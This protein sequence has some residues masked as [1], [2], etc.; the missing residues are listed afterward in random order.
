M[1]SCRVFDLFVREKRESPPGKPMASGKFDAIHNPKN[2]QRRAFTGPHR[3]A[4]D[5][6]LIGGDRTQLDC[7][8]GWFELFAG[9]Q[10]IVRLD[11]AM[12]D[13]SA[14]PRV[15]ERFSNL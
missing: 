11:V 8:V 1:A 2:S 14:V 9:E 5:A 10:E 6:G 15:A 3:Q 7:F 12:N 4:E 13:L